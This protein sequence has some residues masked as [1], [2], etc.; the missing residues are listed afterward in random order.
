[1]SEVAG[2]IVDL[3]TARSPT[4]GS[5]RLICVD[6]P[7]GSGKTT[8]A[9]HLA[10]VCG[11]DVVHTDELM[12]GWRGLDAVARQLITLLEPLAAGRAGHYDR[13][14]WH[15]GR[16]ANQIR[17]EPAP[18]LVMEGVG[19]GAPAIASLC[20]ALVWVEVDDQVRLA[21]GLERDGHALE[22][23]WRQFMK[24]EAALFA[25]DSTR[26]RADVHVDGTGLQPP[27]VRGT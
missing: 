9:G 6:G 20:T 26:D 2:L 21:R 12:D 4:L 15:Q 3:A 5:G 14:D 24:D 13:Y 17:V 7:A 23:P 1:M 16:Y 27:L 22:G 10:A 8:L 11:A 18:W 19:S 25:T